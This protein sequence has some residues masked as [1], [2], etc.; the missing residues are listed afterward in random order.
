MSTTRCSYRR[1]PRPVRGS[2]K[3]DVTRRTFLGTTAGALTAASFA[4]ADEPARPEFSGYL[5]QM[6]FQAGDVLTL[7]VSTDVARFDV[8]IDRVG[9]ERKEVWSRSGVQGRKHATPDDASKAHWVAWTIKLEG[10]LKYIPLFHF[11]LKISFS[12]QF[13][14]SYGFIFEKLFLASYKEGTFHSVGRYFVFGRVY[15][16]TRF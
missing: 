1:R 12:S 15:V 16:S 4:R 6:S 10:L 2:H 9:V 8:A 14:E 7:H 13:L 11:L 3:S 5:N